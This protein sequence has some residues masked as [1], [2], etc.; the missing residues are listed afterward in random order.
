MKIE[1]IKRA[2]DQRPFQ[3]FEIRIADG[4]SI[5]V[6]HPDAL[7]WNDPESP[8]TVLCITEGGGHVAGDPGLEMV[9]RRVVGL[10][11]PARDR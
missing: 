11:I 5:V 10:G 3:P 1:D 4:R 7:A 8:R 9:G 2:K 6:G